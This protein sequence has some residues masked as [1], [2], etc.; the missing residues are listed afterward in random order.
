[1]APKK[2]KPRRNPPR[3]AR[4]KRTA[5]VPSVPDTRVPIPNI[6]FPTIPPHNIPPPSIPLLGLR[7]RQRGPLGTFPFLDLPPEARNPVYGYFDDKNIKLT[8]KETSFEHFETRALLKT[9]ISLLSVSQQVRSEFLSFR[10]NHAELVVWG[11]GDFEEDFL[12][13]A[14]KD[15]IKAVRRLK[16]R[17]PLTRRCKLNAIRL[18]Y[19]RVREVPNI[20]RRWPK[21][22]DS[23]EVIKLCLE[24]HL[25]NRDVPP[26]PPVNTAQWK[27]ALWNH[28][29]RDPRQW[30]ITRRRFQPRS[31]RYKLLGDSPAVRELHF[32]GDR[33]D[34]GD[35]DIIRCVFVF[36]RELQTVPPVTT[37]SQN[38]LEIVTR[39]VSRWL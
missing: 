28:V 8:A 25:H 39:E 14:R 29:C 33:V 18:D 26:L 23:L 32:R 36:R 4:P 12:R 13:I 3:A 22:L 5:V 27:I 6:P 7:P 17:V 15:T 19:P 37:A 1:M 21:L 11:D 31:P 35:Q 34:R 10:W 30:E 16:I 24:P 20:L 38:R 2:S 9:R